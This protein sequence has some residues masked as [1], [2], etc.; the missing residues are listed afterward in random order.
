[1]FKLDIPVKRIEAGTLLQHV[2]RLTYKGTPLHFGKD[3]QSRY[4]DPLKVYGVLYL[5]FDLSTAL[6]ESVFH[7][8][9]WNRG[10]RTISTDEIAKRV[11]RAVGV[12]EDLKLA[13]ITADGVMAAVLGLNLSQLLSRRY[14]NTMRLSAK[15]HQNL[16]PDGQEYDGIYYPSRN[17]Y[18]A[19]CVALFSR[20]ADKVVLAKDLDLARHRDWP[21]F[22]MENKIKI[23]PS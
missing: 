1:M 2:G 14:G 13:H 10:P 12:A 22:V 15:V 20:A 8:H 5:G 21:R 16:D 19:H 3:R 17:N 7:K 23:V 6:M 18:P 9:R 4:D 11:V